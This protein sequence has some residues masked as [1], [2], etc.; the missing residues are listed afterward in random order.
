MPQLEFAAR[1]SRYRGDFRF[2]VTMSE[3]ETLIALSDHLRQSRKE[4]T[5][6][7][8]ATRPDSRDQSAP[9]DTA[10]RYHDDAATFADTITSDTERTLA[11]SGGSTRDGCSAAASS[12]TGMAPSRVIDDPPQTSPWLDTS[13]S[14]NQPPNWWNHSQWDHSRS[15]SWQVSASTESSWEEYGR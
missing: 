15:D 7:N 5:L 8:V 14:D 11:T 3:G 4:L 12:T 10:S 9:P 13:R 2:Y 6:E 1:H